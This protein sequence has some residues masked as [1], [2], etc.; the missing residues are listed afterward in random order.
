MLDAIRDETTEGTSYGGEAEP[1]SHLR[2]SVS[3]HVSIAHQRVDTHS[4][5]CLMFCI[6]ERWRRRSESSPTLGIVDLTI[7]QRNCGAKAG[8]EEAQEDPRCYE[9]GRIVR[10]RL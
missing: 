10:G 6:K 2:G 3:S 7:V 4:Q 5:S 8:F 1:E 9:A